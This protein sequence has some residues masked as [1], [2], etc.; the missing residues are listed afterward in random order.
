MDSELRCTKRTIYSYWYVICFILL[1]T[2]SFAADEW[3]K[4]DITREAVFVG[5][6]LIDWQQTKYIANHDEFTELNPILGKYPTTSEVDRYF[7]IT[8]LGHIA[9]THVLPKKYRPYWQYTW[10]GI[11]GFTV[12]RNFIIGV[13]FNW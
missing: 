12:T 10:I 7:A 2:P 11:Q 9:V 6:Q 8:T 4:A 13:R 1:A 5:L 3:T